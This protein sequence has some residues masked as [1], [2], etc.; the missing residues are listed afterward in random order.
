[1]KTS[2]IEPKNF[3]STP[4]GTLA[5]RHSARLVPGC[6][7][8][9]VLANSLLAYGNL[10]LPAQLWTALLGLAVPLF[11]LFTSAAPKKDPWTTPSFPR[12]PLQAW[13]LLG[14]AAAAFRFFRLTSL[15]SWPVVDEGVFN[16]FAVLLSDHW[17]WRLVHGISQQP[18]LYFWGQALF[19]KA[20]GVSLTTLWLFPAFLSILC[21]PA[22]WLASRRVFTPSLAFFFTA[23]VALGFWPIYIGRISSEIILVVLGELLVFAALA[24]YLTEKDGPRRNRLLLVLGLLTGLGFYTYLGWPIVALF[25]ALTLLSRRHPSLSGR[26]MTA[27]KYGSLAVAAAIPLFLTYLQRYQGYLGHLWVAGT[28]RPWWYHAGLA[29]SYMRDLFWGAGADFYHYGPLWGGLLNPVLTSLFGLGLVLVLRSRR[30]VLSRWVLLGLALFSLPALLTNN[31][32]AMR[33]VLLLP[34][35]LGVCAMG[36]LSLLGFIPASRRLPLFLLLLGLS[37]A[38]DARH[39]FQVHPRHW[40]EHPSYYGEHK[41]REFYKAYGVLEPLARKEGPGSILLN[42]H[43]DPYDQSLFVATHDMNA[44]LRSSPSA[45]LWAAFLVNA[46][47]RPL[48]AER[49]LDGPWYWLSEGLGRRDGGSLLKVVQITSTNKELLGRWVKADGSLKELTRL[50]MEEGVNPDQGRMLRVLA[51]AYPNFKGDRFLESRYWRIM[52]MH[53]LAEGN[54][55]EAIRDEEKAIERGYP[56]AHL[57][58]EMGCLLFKEGHT[59]EAEKAFREALKRKLNLT[60][61]ASNLQNLLLDQERIG[62]K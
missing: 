57:Y 5:V 8:V 40:L 48:L 23:W 56:M 15:F 7:L 54:R 20:F 34:L 38:L 4:V 27:L 47:E 36:A 1:M 33:L 53:H 49:S 61:A 55:K 60:D 51:E 44:S 26:I 19:D 59:A 22:A 3:F 30:Q 50:V 2:K 13:L 28:P 31:L 18:T 9:L 29:S 16:Y 24:H 10:S 21:V 35:V 11:I 37:A 62:K 58:N 6:F 41:S 45:P 32:E 42:F 12:V 25:I 17:D 14:L 52:A 46:H 43:P 39:L